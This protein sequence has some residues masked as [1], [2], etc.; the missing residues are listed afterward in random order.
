MKRILSLLIIT[1]FGLSTYGADLRGYDIN[2]CEF[3]TSDMSGTGFNCAGWPRTV[4]V[5]EA[6]SFAKEI[7][8]LERKIADLEKR[9]HELE[10]NKTSSI[11]E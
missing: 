6:S 4:R 2:N 3:W 7:G 9:L 8:I 10:K 5:A 1:G 11:E